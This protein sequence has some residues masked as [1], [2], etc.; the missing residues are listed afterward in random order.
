LTKIKFVLTVIATTLTLVFSAN[1]IFASK[2]E[3]NNMFTIIFKELQEI[4][5]DINQI[6]HILIDK[7]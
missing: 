2:S 5:T 4:R 7:L 3:T 1:M 6:K